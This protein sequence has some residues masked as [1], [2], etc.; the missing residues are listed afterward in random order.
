VSRN[1]VHQ[2]SR[3]VPGTLE[4]AAAEP[5]PYAAIPGPRGLDLYR[6]LPGFAKRPLET[7]QALTSKYGDIVSLPYPLDRVVVVRDP[8]GV[9]HVLH[10]AHH[11]Y[12]K[13]TQRWR[14]LRQIW[15]EGLVTADGDAWRR[16][17]QRIQPAFHEQYVQVFA[18]TMVAEAERVGDEWSAAARSGQ[19]RDVYTDMLRCTLR[20]LL[21]AMFGSDIEAK[22][23]VLIKVVADVTGYVDPTAPSNLLN[24]PIP[25]RRWV[26]A[27]FKPYQRAMDQVRELFGEIITR[28]VGSGETR[29]DLLGLVMA[30]RD[31]ERSETMS[32]RQV[33]DEMMTLLMTGH[34]TSGISS[35]WTWYWLSRN[36]EP[37]RRLHAELDAVLGGRPPGPEDLPSLEYT[38]RTFDE[39]LRLSPPIYAVDR[40]AIEDDCVCGYRIPKGVSVL[41]SQY[42]MHRHPKYW[43]DPLT[44]DPDRFLPAQAAKRPP[45]SYFPFGGGP[46]RCVGMRLALM[47]LPLLIATLARR[48]RLRLKPGHPVEELA[49][50]NLAPRYGMQML[51]EERQRGEAPSAAPA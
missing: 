7:L 16:Q 29:T 13:T 41:I 28:R 22:V 46:R 8:A 30:G 27:G 15:G 2:T 35:T 31:E 11:R 33:H 51:I 49:R 45:Y 43:D 18:R 23:D 9:E 10:Y 17:R 34:E 5:A 42:L 25:V 37:E 36:P 20:A 19:P 4:D 21:K 1:E 40:Q 50:V 24:L 3:D 14:T 39:V 47:A 6:Q 48:Y 12:A 38:R 26:S 44:F 32:L